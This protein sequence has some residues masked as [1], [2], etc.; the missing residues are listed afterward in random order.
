MNKRQKKKFKRKCN[1]KKYRD[2]TV[3]VFPKPYTIIGSIDGITHN[4]KEIDIN[5]TCNKYEDPAFG[6][7][8]AEYLRW[9]SGLKKITET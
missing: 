1:H 2:F 8:Y 7:V 3:F 4:Q 9:I 5:F 6:E